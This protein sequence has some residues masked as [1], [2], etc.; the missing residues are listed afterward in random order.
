[1]AGW[2]DNFRRVISGTP[3]PD[4]EAERAEKRNALRKLGIH[5]TADRDRLAVERARENGVY[6]EMLKRSG[7]NSRSPFAVQAIEARKNRDA[8]DAK[9]RQLNA[10]L[11]PIETLLS[12]ANMRQIDATFQRLMGDMVKVESSAAAGPTRQ[13]MHQTVADARAVVMNAT[14]IDGDLESLDVGPLES[15]AQVDADFAADYAAVMASACVVPPAARQGATS[16]A[17]PAV[18]A[19]TRDEIHA[20][21]LAALMRRP[22][23]TYAELGEQ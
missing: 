3:E 14:G 15:T 5:I 23:T 22:P 16:A 2:F 21:A 10:R 11:T 13:E 9:I 8:L 12:A 4:P 18:S 17:A 7:G 1:M 20:Q 19:A 6:T